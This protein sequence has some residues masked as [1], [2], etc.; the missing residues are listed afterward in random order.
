MSEGVNTPYKFQNAA[1]LIVGGAAL[2]G[3]AGRHGKFNFTRR[4]WFCSSGP[5]REYL[6]CRRWS[7]G[8]G[9]HGADL[10]GG[11]GVG[12]VDSAITLA[13]RDATLTKLR[14]SEAHYR[15]L[16]DAAFE[17]LHQRRGASRM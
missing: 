12:G 17:G 6:K 10:H 15:N 2:P 13:E 7:S 11:G 16:T 9:F 1:I 14:A 3:G 8:Y 4:W 5:R